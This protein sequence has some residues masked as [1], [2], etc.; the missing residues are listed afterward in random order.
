MTIDHIELME[1]D[2]AFAAQV[3]PVCEAVGMDPFSERFNQNGGAIAL[4]HPFGMTGARTMTTLLNGLEVEGRP[5][6]LE[7]MCRRWPGHGDDRRAPDVRY[8]IAQ[9]R[10]LWCHSEHA[11]T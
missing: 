2:E 10:G 11:W 6:G 4:S 1:L 7:S 5:I 3:L 8:P 9:A